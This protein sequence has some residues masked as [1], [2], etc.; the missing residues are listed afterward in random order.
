MAW[1]YETKPG[2][3]SDGIGTRAS[4]IGV[5][6]APGALGPTRPTQVVTP[7]VRD[8]G[9]AQVVSMRVGAA[10]CTRGRR[11][12]YDGARPA[13]RPPRDRGRRPGR[14]PPWRSTGGDTHETQTV[15]FFGGPVIGPGPGP[16]GPGP[17]PGR[18]RRAARKGG[19]PTDSV[20]KV[21]ATIRSPDPLHPWTKQSP[22]EASGTGVVI[23]GKRILTNAHVVLYA[24]Q[25]FVESHQSSD[26]LAATV[27][28]VSPGID[29]AVLKLEDESFFDKRPAAAA[30]ARRC[31]RSRT[32]VLVYGYPQGGRSL[33]VTKGIVSRIEFAGYNERRLGPPRSRSTPRSTPATAAARPWSTTR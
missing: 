2:I 19:A 18:R 13:G 33:S 27:E 16:G 8:R 1:F 30:D 7:A 5:F 24:S 9:F 25:L 23:E 12:G 14:A 10:P 21:F 11:A 3:G 29:L 26:K 15:G 28:A 4:R 32:A 17:G 20:V 31:P 22:R 6:G